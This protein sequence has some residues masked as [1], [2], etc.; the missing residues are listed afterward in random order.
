MNDD[1]QDD[2]APASQQLQVLPRVVPM[3]TEDEVV[4]MLAEEARYQTDEETRSVAVRLLEA[5][6]TVQT[7]ARK[8]DVRA[9]T[10]WRWSGEPVVKAAVAA[11][12]E[13]RRSV[14]GEGLENAADGA[15]GALTSIVGDVQVSPRDRIKAAEAILDRCGLVEVRNG[16]E[17]GAVVAIDVDFD[18]RLARIVATAGSKGS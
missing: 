15:L 3:A 7:V 13:R 8:L 18:E 17:T 4:A 5:G 2:V 12:K 10:V 16:G 1:I 6:Y 11:G 14:L 9:S